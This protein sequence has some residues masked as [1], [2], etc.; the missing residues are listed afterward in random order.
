VQYSQISTLG[1][2]IKIQVKLC[3]V[4]LKIGD[5]MWLLYGGATSI[6][7]FHLIVADKNVF[8]VIL[9]FLV[10]QMRHWCHDIFF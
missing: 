2:D 5:K 9:C 8:Y 10:E 1:I 6:A 3:R 4:L 7:F